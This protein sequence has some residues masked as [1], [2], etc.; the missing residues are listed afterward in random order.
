[1]IVEIHV[2]GGQAERIGAGLEQDVGEDRD[3]VAP[4]DDALD[5]AQRLQQ[6]AAFDGQFHGGQKTSQDVR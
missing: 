2:G 3:G 1:M 4:L 6:S 5:M